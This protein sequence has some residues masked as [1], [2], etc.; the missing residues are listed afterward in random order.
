MRWAMDNAEAIAK[1]TPEIPPGFHNRRRANWRPLLAIAEAAGSE[2]KTAAWKAALAIEAV[3]DTFD[4]SIGVELLQAIKAAFEARAKELRNKDRITAPGLITDLAADETARW[5]T[6]NKG[7]PISQAQV[8]R[9]L[10]P[11]GIKPKTIRWDDGTEDGSY[12]KGYLLE[13][14]ADVFSRF[15]TFSSS[16][17]LDS[18]FHTS[19]DLFSPDFSDFHKTSTSPYVEVGKS[20]DNNDVEAFSGKT[21]G[22]AQK[23]DS[24]PCS[25]CGRPDG[26]VYSMRDI[27]RCDPLKPPPGGMP[28]V[29]LH[30]GCTQAFFANCTAEPGLSPA[31][32]RELAAWYLARATAQHEANEAGDISSAELDAALRLIL[33]EEVFP[34]FV[35]MEFGRVMKAVFSEIA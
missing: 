35:E 29:H 28:M 16:G 24:Q 2:W 15:C 23:E 33:R 12:P 7:K 8:A 11:Y 14:F 6:Y 4:P 19:T 27:R 18:T 25:H 31:R 10:K 20:N 26:I 21:G 17:T 22:Q 13:W 1:A 30:E 5:A 32:I 34:E 9:L 3:A